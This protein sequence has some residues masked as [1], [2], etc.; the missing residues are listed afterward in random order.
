[1]SERC[2]VFSFGV[3]LLEL[4]TGQQ[5]SACPE[6]KTEH[7]KDWAVRHTRASRGGW[8]RIVDPRLQGAYSPQAAR[9]SVKAAVQCVSDDPKCRPQMA[10][11]VDTLKVAYQQACAS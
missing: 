9:I 4:I 11:I 1:M 2:D 6:Q 7:M 8:Q 3:V 5:A 10:V